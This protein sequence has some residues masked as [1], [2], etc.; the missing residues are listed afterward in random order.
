MKATLLVR[1]LN[2]NES[3]APG[4]SPGA[5][6]TSSHQAKTM[7]HHAKLLKQHNSKGFTLTEAVVAVAIIGSLAAIATPK[8]FNQ[9]QAN[10]QRQNQAFMSQLLSQTQA[11]YDEFGD[12]PKGWSDLD[13]IATIQTTN[14]PASGDSFSAIVIPG[15]NYS[16][17]GSTSGNNFI[18]QS[19]FTTPSSQDSEGSETANTNKLNVIGCINTRTGA[20]D[21]KRGDGTQAADASDLN[22]G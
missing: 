15:C 5:K 18:Y 17:T 1:G 19:V 21:I 22:C 4:F 3:K 9:I 14:G 2:R 7:K 8:Y 10:C 20:S 13:R 11:Y 12:Q 6:N 16:Y